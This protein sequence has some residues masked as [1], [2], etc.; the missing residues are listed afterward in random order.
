MNEGTFSA[1]PPVPNPERWSSKAIPARL[2]V[3]RKRMEKLMPG[4][5]IL[6]EINY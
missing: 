3:R 5:E 1:A 6:S 2:K 4:G